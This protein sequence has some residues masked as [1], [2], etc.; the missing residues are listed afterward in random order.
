MHC[1]LKGLDFAVMHAPTFLL[2]AGL[3]LHHGLSDREG[4]GW[5]IGCP[6][7]PESSGNRCKDETELHRKACCGDGK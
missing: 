7:P 3:H 6:A 4:L 2:Q 1:T 5:A